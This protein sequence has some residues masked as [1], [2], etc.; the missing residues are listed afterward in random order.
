MGAR[1]AGA[2]FYLRGRACIFCVDRG[3]DFGFTGLR[4]NPLR[5][6]HIDVPATEDKLFLLSRSINI[7]PALPRCMVRN[8]TP[9]RDPF[10]RA[11]RKM[12]PLTSRRIS[13][14]RDPNCQPQ[15]RVPLGGAAV[16]VAMT[17]KESLKKNHEK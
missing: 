14:V 8:A 10:D 3:N 13:N 16:C 5:V 1:L 6:F 17:L 15:V 11:T 2:A 4:R 9:L 12:K 7:S